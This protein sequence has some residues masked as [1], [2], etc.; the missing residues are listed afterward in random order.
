MCPVNIGYTAGIETTMVAPQWLQK[1]NEM[2]KILVVSNHA[3]QTYVDTTAQARNPQTG[4]VFPYKLET[5][6]EVVWESTPRS[7]PE[8]IPGLELPTTNNMLMVSQFSVR[9]NFQNALRWWVERFKD[10]DVGLVVKTNIAGNCRMDLEMTE[11]TLQGILGEYQDRKCKV[12][13]LHGDLSNGQ[14][15]W[16]YNHEKIDA[17]VNIAHGEGFGLPMFEAA[18]EGMPI[19]TI[20]WSGQLD[21]LTHEG[22]SYFEEVESTLQPIQQHAVWDGVIQ[23]D[24]MWAYADEDSYKQ[25][26]GNVIE[27]LDSLNEKA[28]KL[29]SIIEEKFEDKKLH[30]LFVDNILGFDS[31][32]IEPEEEETF[33]MEFE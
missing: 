16:L 26:L 15:T 20:G 14:M 23:A 33:V 3:K 30:K 4:E 17:L 18:R 25:A 5:D 11:S 7:E 1:G 21:F 31:S 24:S 9:K 29:K 28:Q 22:E 32:I 6:V 13:L 8:A 12:Y 19:V 27:N 2:D 10:E